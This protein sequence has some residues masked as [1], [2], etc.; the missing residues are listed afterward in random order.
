MCHFIAILRF[1]SYLPAIDTCTRHHFCTVQI[2][3]NECLSGKHR[4]SKNEN[5]TKHLM[6]FSF[7]NLYTQFVSAWNP[8][9]YGLSFDNA[10]ATRT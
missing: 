5:N 9:E 6:G 8:L 7:G 1:R 2:N 3:S 4:F 10:R